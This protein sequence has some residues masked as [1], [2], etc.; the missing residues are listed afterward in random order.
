MR[1]MAILFGASAFVYF[2][3]GYVKSFSRRKRFIFALAT[4]IIVYLVIMIV[5]V[6]GDHN[7]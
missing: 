5:F 2:L 6:L 4:Y 1:L 3:T 7:F